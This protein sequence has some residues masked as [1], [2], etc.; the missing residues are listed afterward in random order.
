M[1]V[2]NIRPLGDDAAVVDWTQVIDGGELR[3][4]DLHL[5]AVVR[6]EGSDWRI[7][8]CRPYAF[9]PLPVPAT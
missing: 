1:D 2:E 9:L 3:R 7:V 5:V 8:D 6:R 4:L